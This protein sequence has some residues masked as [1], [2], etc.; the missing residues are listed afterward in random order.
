M[1]R[2]VCLLL[3]S[4]T[5][6]IALENSAS[7][8][9]TPQLASA[10]TWDGKPVVYPT[11]TAEVTTLMI[12]VA[13]GGETGWHKHPVPSFALV[14]EGSLEVHLKDGRTHRARAGDVLYEVVDTWHNGRNVGEGTLKLFVTYAGAKGQPLTIKEPPGE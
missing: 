12:E 1:R 4:I 5:N 3:L 11:G 6:A 2:F 9:V 10:T 7:V 14:L 13:P 8:K